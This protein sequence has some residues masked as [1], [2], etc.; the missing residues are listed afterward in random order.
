MLFLLSP[1]SSS[2]VFLSRIYFYFA[3]AD[4]ATEWKM[5][6]FLFNSVAVTFNFQFVRE[7]FREIQWS[8]K[9]RVVAEVI[10][11][12]NVFHWACCLICRCYYSRGDLDKKKKKK[13]SQSLIVD[14]LHNSR[15]GEET[16]KDFWFHIFK[17]SFHWKA[18]SYQMLFC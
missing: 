13:K 6:S 10:G 9:T 17:A 15:K 2:S 16:L 8:V 5:L 7:C 12:Q 3:L 14:E 11:V 1:H 4:K 18:L